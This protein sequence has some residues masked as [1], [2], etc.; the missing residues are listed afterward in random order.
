MKII[1]GFFKIEKYRYSI[2]AEDLAV[3]RSTPYH[4]GVYELDPFFENVS[5]PILHLVMT[6]NVSKEFLKEIEEFT[7][8]HYPHNNIDWV[9][10]QKMVDYVME[11]KKLCSESFSQIEEGRDGH[12]IRPL[13]PVRRIKIAK[14]KENVLSYLNDKYQPGMYALPS[15]P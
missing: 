9:V 10:T 14:I 3:P 12:Y 4:T 5:Q 15:V 6:K 11:Y 1:N 13:H 7:K 8:S 2:W